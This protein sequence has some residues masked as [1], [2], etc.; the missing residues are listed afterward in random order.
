MVNGTVTR[1]E[2]TSSPVAGTIAGAVP[3]TTYTV[4][5][6][7]PDPKPAFPI[8]HVFHVWVSPPFTVPTPLIWNRPARLV[9]GPWNGVPGVVGVVDRSTTSPGAPPFGPGAKVGAVGLLK[10]GL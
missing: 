6:D 10:N 1:L 7:A 9:F 8:C 4:S 2:I 5:I 3:L